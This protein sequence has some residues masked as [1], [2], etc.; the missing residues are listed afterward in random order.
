MRLRYMFT[1][2]MFVAVIMFIWMPQVRAQI[3]GHN[4]TVQW[5]DGC[6]ERKG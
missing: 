3:D 4:Y 6:W 1:I 5:D 2:T